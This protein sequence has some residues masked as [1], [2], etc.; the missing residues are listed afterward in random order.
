[1]NMFISTLC[2]VTGFL[3]GWWARGRNAENDKLSARLNTPI[4][5]RRKWDRRKPPPSL[6]SRSLVTP[7][8]QRKK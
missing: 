2:L 4:K 8:A 5:D 1:M 6:V 7:L 3:I